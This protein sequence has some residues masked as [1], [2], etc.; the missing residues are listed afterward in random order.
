M[1]G[2]LSWFLVGDIHYPEY[3]DA[4][5][6][7]IKDPN[8]P[9]AMRASI[10]SARLPNVFKYILK[11]IEGGSCNGVMFCGDLTSYGDISGY[12]D[13]VNYI[14]TIFSKSM[15]TPGQLSLCAVPGNHDICRAAFD[16]T[17]Y[18][19]S[20]ELLQKVWPTGLKTTLP[21]R[22][23]VE[24]IIQ[25]PGG[26]CHVFSV[27][28]CCGCG[29]KRQTLP[30]QVSTGI[31]ESINKWLA[32]AHKDEVNSFLYETL[33]APFI[34]HEVICKIKQLLKCVD[35][36]SLPIIL[37]HHNILPQATPRLA[38]YTEMID[39]GSF[40][41]ALLEQGR[42][43]LYFH[44]HLHEFFVH[45][46]SHENGS[47]APLVIVSAPLAS[48]GVV[49]ITIQY[50]VRG[51]PMGCIIS[52]M[53]LE[54]YGQFVNRRD[55]RIALGNNKAT[56]AKPTPLCNV[57]LGQIDAMPRDESV[58]WRD[59]FGA[60]E[61]RAQQKGIT[62]NETDV[63]SH[64][65]EFEWEGLVKVANRKSPKLSAWQIERAN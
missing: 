50:G 12:T 41:S 23:S 46:I 24:A 42:P 17:K 64:I 30:G 53:A 55:I 37:A 62:A 15:T 8:A 3:K 14:D 20:V 36:D 5:I 49:K 6:G 54:N 2:E 43:I 35:V 56:K 34:S 31:Q 51:N 58:M 47:D 1:P 21:T 18:H 10:T 39:S 63:S 28:S 22:D 59:F 19:E 13:C 52:H 29:I 65:L 4:V 40:R 57:V 48:D 60:V 61:K 38:P 7:D 33:D 32:V 45:T 9:E 11:E 25:R 16:E 27:N 44:G 26:K